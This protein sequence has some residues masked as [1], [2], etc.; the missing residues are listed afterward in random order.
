M[1]SFS[2]LKTHACRL[3]DRSFA[4]KYN[5]QRHI[6]SVH[7]EEQSV[8]SEENSEME[9]NSQSDHYEPLYKRPRTNEYR[10]H[11]N[12]D[13][14]S[15][16]DNFDS[17]REG[18]DEELKEDEEEE[19]EE[20]EEY[21][22]SDL[23]DNPTYQDWLEEAKEDTEDIW[24]PKYEKYINEGMSEDQ[25]REKANMKTLWAVKR[26]FFA[27]F[28]DFLSSYVHLKDENTYQEIIGDLEEKMEKGVDIN[29][30]LNRVV[31]SYKSKF[32]GLFHEESEEEEEEEN[33]ND[34]E[35]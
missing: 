25:A 6:D 20:E 22:S 30:A 8:N 32:T 21:S 2:V 7:C 28:K 10:D 24:K 31:S 33:E 9:Y 14:S 23:E 11:E 35:Q 4:K 19:E 17:E 12:D 34:E 1:N 18:D 15:E 27:R 29:K 5:L 16:E 3:C 13:E 26:N